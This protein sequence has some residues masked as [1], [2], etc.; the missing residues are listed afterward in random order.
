MEPATCTLYSWFYHYL[1]DIKVLNRYAPNNRAS[2]IT[3][4]EPKLTGLQRE[5]DTPTI[6]VDYF[7]TPFSIT[8]RTRRQTIIF[9][10]SVYLAPCPVSPWS[11]LG[12]ESSGCAKPPSGILGMESWMP[13]IRMYLFHYFAF[14]VS[15]NF[16]LM[17]VS[18]S[19]S[20]PVVQSS[21]ARLPTSKPPFPT[22]ELC[23]PGQMICPLWCLF[24]FCDMDIWGHPVS[25]SCE[26]YLKQYLGDT[27]HSAHYHISEPFPSPVSESQGWFVVVVFFPVA[28]PGP[29]GMPDS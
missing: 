15:V 6:I 7:K 3:R 26:E 1:K 12:M 5:I 23:D 18:C 29:R 13:G 9:L 28:S 4:N 8:S 27:E 22:D 11:I 10:N 16:I 25:L 19:Q 21:G 14:K 2:S 24:I 17:T 20:S